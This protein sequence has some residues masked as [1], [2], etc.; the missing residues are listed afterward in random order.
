MKMIRS[1]TLAHSYVFNSRMGLV[2]AER[3]VASIL[4]SERAIDMWFVSLSITTGTLAM[5]NLS[6]R[7]R[8]R[9]RAFTLIELLVVI[10]IIA[11]LIA[12]LLPAVQAAREAARRM[13]CTNNLK[14]ITLAIHNYID[15]N[16]VTPLHEYRYATEGG[17]N[18]NAGTHSWYCG[19]APFLEQ[20]TMYN[21]MNFVYTREW[22]YRP[23]TR[24]EPDR[25]HGQQGQYRDASLSVRRDRQYGLRIREMDQLSAR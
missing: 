7:V 25:P 15:V 2:P 22:E 10:A 21:S 16:N 17:N 13:Q 23:G 8:E 9:K 12:L 14:Q 11:V 20:M 5:I 24:A 1:T 19:I 6:V 4:Q 18:G 3:P